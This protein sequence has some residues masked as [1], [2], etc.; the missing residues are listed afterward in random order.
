MNVAACLT[1]PTRMETGTWYRSVQPKYYAT[2]LATVHT[3]LQSS[4][5]GQGASATTPYEVLYLTE[6]NVVAQFEVGALYGDPFGS[7]FSSPPVPA[8][9]WVLLYVTVY[10]QRIVDLVQVLH[11]QTL[12]T[13][14]QELT[15]DWKGYQ[16]RKPGHSVQQPIGTA[17]TQDLGAALF[18]TPGIEGFRIVSAKVPHSCNL[19]IF[20]EKLDLSSKITFENQMTGAID[21][22]P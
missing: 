18:A 12:H 4:R 2:A 22:I 10:L 3:R 17:P 1:L 7:S 13:T 19:V 8:Q 15:G 21:T 14:A 5:Y 11:Q 6:N 20:P 9:T 16:M